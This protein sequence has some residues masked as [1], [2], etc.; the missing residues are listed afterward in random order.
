M[1]TSSHPESR[2]S[3]CLLEWGGEK[4]APPESLQT[5]GVATAQTFGLINLVFSRETGV[6][7][8]EHPFL[9]K[10]HD[11]HN[12]A[13]C[14][15]HKA[16]RPRVRFSKGPETIIAQLLAHNPVNFASLTDIKYITF[17]II[18]TLILIANTKQLFRPER[19]S[20]L[21]RN[22]PLVRSLIRTKH[23]PQSKNTSQ[24]PKTLPR[25]QKHFPESGFWKVF[26]ILGR[27]LD[28]GKCFGFW[29]VFLDSGKCFWIL[30]SVLDAGK[31]FWILG[32]VLS[33]R[34]TVPWA[35]NYLQ[36]RCRTC[37]LSSWLNKDLTRFMQS[38]SWVPRQNGA[39]ERKA[40][41]E[42]IQLI[43]EILLVHKLR[44]KKVKTSIWE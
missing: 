9:H 34:A 10:L 41:L 44:T 12:R 28:S 40:P 43:Q 6:F 19:F 26:W 18:G 16:F 31:C 32:S 39:S 33:L 30:E 20:G 7:E 29:D 37:S 2:A 21:S 3:F 15:K 36:A 13:C 24:N 1:L 4:K 35:R 8:G 11:G 23:T 14:S 5:F 22:R 42:G 38:L 27:V 25:I 17:K